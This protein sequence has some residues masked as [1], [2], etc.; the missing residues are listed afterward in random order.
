MIK[1]I[2]DHE[3]EILSLLFDSVWYLET[4]K[5]VAEVKC[6]PLDHYITFGYKEGRNPNRFFNTNFYLIAY[7]DIA[8][9]QL[10][11]FIHYIL[12]GAAEGRLPR[13]QGLPPLPVIIREIKATKDSGLKS[14]E[15]VVANED[16]PNSQE[17]KAKIKVKQP[18]R[19]SLK[20]TKTSSVAEKKIETELVE[21]TKIKSFLKA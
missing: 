16:K 21:D 7:P 13:P 6:D 14:L 18:K 5:D 20:S 10:N 3:I 11:P 8:A 12:Y 17:E 4:Y 1:N 19:S 9:S 2:N 15:D